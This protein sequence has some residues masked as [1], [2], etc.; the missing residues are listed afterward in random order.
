MKII[1]YYNILSQTIIK[2]IIA[3]IIIK[4]FIKEFR[5]IFN[6]YKLKYYS[7]LPIKYRIRQQH[8]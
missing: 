2:D 7:T 4:R 6:Y 3:G 8:S 5:K 1:N